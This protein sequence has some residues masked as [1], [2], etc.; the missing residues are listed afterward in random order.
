MEQNSRKK[1]PAVTMLLAGI[2]IVVWIVL[3]LSGNTSDGGYMLRKGASYLPYIVE[4]GEWWRIIT[5]MFL[6][7]GSEHL[8]NNMLMLG[9]MGM[10]LEHAM[11]SVCFAVLYLFSGVCGALLSLYVSMRTGDAAVSAGASG[12][13]F[14]VAGGLLAW[15]LFHRGKVEGL[16]ARGLCFMAF[17]SLYYGFT[18]GGVDNAGH[19]GGLLGGF[20][21]GCAIALI[22]RIVHPH[23]RRDETCDS[24]NPE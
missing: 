13:I 23:R 7:F 19:I 15:A 18:A 16:S 17:L 11:G 20:L 2:N 10:R 24:V 5:S 21:L 6:H 4:D 1:L 3:E 12:A 8:V 14:G 9:L 22:L